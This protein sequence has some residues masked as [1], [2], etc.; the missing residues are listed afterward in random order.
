MA[1]SLSDLA[2]PYQ[3]GPNRPGWQ[4][5]EG[6]PSKRKALSYAHANKIEARAQERFEQ[7]QAE[8]QQ[9]Q[10]TRQAWRDAGKKPR[11]RNPKAWLP[12]PRDTDQVNLIDEESGIMP[13][14][15][16]R[17]EQCYNAQAGVDT[18]TMLVVSARTTQVTKD[19]Q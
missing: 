13:L 6:E 10:A 16:G 8:C 15:G 14:S 1:R 19:K 3:G 17:F 4:H 5:G 11:G 9:K 7:E 18:E 12:G 2:H